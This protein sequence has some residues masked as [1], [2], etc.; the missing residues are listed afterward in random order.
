M[1]QPGC[2]S[3]ADVADRQVTKEP[4]WQ[5]LIEVDPAREVHCGGNRQERSDAEV[6]LLNAADT[7]TFLQEDAAAADL[8]KGLVAAVA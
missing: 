5:P 8:P 3:I 4:P 1:C 2:R 6:H 7:A